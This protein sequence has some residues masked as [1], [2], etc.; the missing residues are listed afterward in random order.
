MRRRE[1]KVVKIIRG[2]K[3]S[4]LV[5]D[6]VFEIFSIY[7]NCVPKNAHLQIRKQ[8]VLTHN[9]ANAEVAREEVGEEARGRAEHL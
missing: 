5:F 2:I 7:F 3:A 8:L 4:V 9:L 1:G 6:I